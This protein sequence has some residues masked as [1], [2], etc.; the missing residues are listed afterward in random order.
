MDDMPAHAPGPVADRSDRPAPHGRP[1]SSGTATGAQEVLPFEDVDEAADEPIAFSLTARARRTVAPEALPSLRVIGRSTVASP[2]TGEPSPPVDD[3][4]SPPVDDDPADTRPARARALRRAGTEVPAIAGQLGV[5][6][7]LVRAWV[8]GVSGP[9]GGRRSGVR[10]ISHPRPFVP[11]AVPLHPGG[12]DVATGAV[13]TAGDLA[14]SEA[15]AEARRRLAGD[16]QL[17]TGLGLLAGTVEVDATTVTV[18]TDDPRVAGAIRRWLVA[19]VAVD[20]DA[21][22]VLVRLGPRAAGDLARHR[23]ARALEVPVD[24]VRTTRWAAAPGPDAVDG[25][26]RIVD[27]GAAAVVAGWRD[28]LLDGDLDEDPAF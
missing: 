27:A 15:R 13:R 6:D 12:D 8:D 18:A 4:P 23:W 24:R 9:A 20:P 14:R 16:H 19:T 1:P 26:L 22:R 17:A 11:P 7:L 3:D 5:D 21:I 25:L 28:A 10:S 2:V